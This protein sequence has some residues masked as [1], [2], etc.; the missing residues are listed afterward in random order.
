[1][2]LAPMLIE[3][4]RRASQV[5]A[6]VGLTQSR[7][8]A[9]TAGAALKLAATMRKASR[10]PFLLYPRDPHRCVLVSAAGQRP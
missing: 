1:M 2:S 8:S 6:V 3:Q 5:L 7:V 9:L 10:N 4:R